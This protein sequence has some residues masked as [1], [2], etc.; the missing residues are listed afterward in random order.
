M[1]N[2]HN[3]LRGVLYR[4]EGSSEATHL[5]HFIYW[6]DRAETWWLALKCQAGPLSP[7]PFLC[8]G[9]SILS[10]VYS[11]VPAWHTIPG[12]SNKYNNMVVAG[13]LA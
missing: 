10:H 9:Y 11:A 8:V 6:G 2:H 5:R 7:S 4:H 3:R 1:Y 13:M 12:Y